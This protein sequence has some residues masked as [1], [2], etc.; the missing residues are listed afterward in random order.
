MDIRAKTRLLGGIS[1]EEF[2]RRYWQKKPLLVRGA[3]QDVAATGALLSRAELL[4]LAGREGVESRLVVRDPDDRWH[5]RHGPFARRALPALKRPEWTVLVQGVDLHHQGV[6]EL[7]QRFRF[8]PEA[9]LDDLMISFATDGGGVGPHFDHYDVFLLQMH[10]QRVWRIGRQR[11][12]RLRD[13]LPLKILSHFEPEDEYLLEPGDMLYLPPRYAHDGVALG[14]CMT[15][16]VGFRTPT[17]G[18]VARELL[19]RLADEASELATAELA[20]AD[21]KQPATEVPGLIPVAMHE[22]ARAAIERLLAEPDMLARNVGE[23]LTDPKANVWFDPAQ[24]PSSRRGA[25]RGVRLDRRSR[26]MYDARHLYLNGESWR[27]AGADARLMRKLAD[28]RR[29]DAADL[30]AAS[31]DALGL[32]AQWREAGWLHDQ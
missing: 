19:Q 16:S 2:M 12:L 18:E 25:A 31:A 7:M 14:E 23:Y 15:Y 32:I 24:R 8:V 5:V 6:H 22:F 1:P 4:E 29:L 26:M 17:R 3:V 13:D 30:A 11:D 21:P 27:A 28:A 20:Y 10:G 9:R